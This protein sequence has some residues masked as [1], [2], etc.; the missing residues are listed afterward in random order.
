MRVI[1]SRSSAISFCVIKR[2][3]LSN[4]NNESGKSHATNKNEMQNSLD[5]QIEEILQKLKIQILKSV[6]TII[7]QLSLHFTHLEDK[8]TL[9]AGVFLDFF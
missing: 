7:D 9:M 1:E 5:S 3:V 6:A 8:V 2:F 4:G